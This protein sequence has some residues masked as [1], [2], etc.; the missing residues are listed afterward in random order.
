MAGVT[1]SSHS[2]ASQA[3]YRVTR[4]R[5]ADR[6]NK[7][8]KRSILKFARTCCSAATR[9]STSDSRCRWRRQTPF[10]A[11]ISSSRIAT[12]PMGGLRCRMWCWVSDWMV[13]MTV[14]VSLLI[15]APITLPTFP[16][17]KKDKPRSGKFAIAAKRLKTRNRRCQAKTE[18]A[19]KVE[20]N[21]ELSAFSWAY[22]LLCSEKLS[23]NMLI[24]RRYQQETRSMA[25]S[26]DSPEHSKHGG[27]SF[28]YCYCLS[29]CS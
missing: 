12:A 24:S 18:A 6:T 21:S 16:V 2:G 26:V 11:A 10:L 13:G 4:L 3:R 22:K 8:R 7:C 1:P 25:G 14:F 19:V 17:P 23:Q 15:R 20:N 29:D 5:W 9:F 28:Q 27:S